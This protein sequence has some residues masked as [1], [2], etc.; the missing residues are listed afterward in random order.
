MEYIKKVIF[1][2]LF[3]E[4]Q[5]HTSS[6]NSNSKTHK[7]S[8]NIYHSIM[9]N[10]FLFHQNIFL[11]NHC[12]DYKVF[13]KIV[14]IIKLYFKKKTCKKSNIFNELTQIYELFST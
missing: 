13:T 14:N 9:Y 6:K 1:L 8:Y 5:R 10:F 11:K 2:S 12:S 3:I 7:K 4:Y